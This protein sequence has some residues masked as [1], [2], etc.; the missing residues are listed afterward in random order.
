M[1][2]KNVTIRTI[3]QPSD[4]NRNGNIFGGW[5]LSQMDIAGGVEAARC[6]NGI[7]ATVAIEGMKFINPILLNDIISIYADVE[8]V[9]NTSMTIFIE[10]FA[11]RGTDQVEIKVTEARYIFVALD[12]KGNPRPV[13][14]IDSLTV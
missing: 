3:P 14:A 5:I 12:D 1:T 8:K 10:V 7:V 6:A 2:N 9:G 13:K 4:I 11:S